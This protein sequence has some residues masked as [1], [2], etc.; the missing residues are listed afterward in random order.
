MKKTILFIV[1]IFFIGSAFAQLSMNSSGVVTFSKGF[2][3]GNT[4]NYFAADMKIKSTSMGYPSIT[5]IKASGYVGINVGPNTVSYPLDCRGTV[6]GYSFHTYSDARVKKNILDIENEQIWNILKLIP[7]E[8]ELDSTGSYIHPL[9]N[10]LTHKHFGLLAQDVKKIY[11]EIVSENND[12]L[13]SINYIELIP[14]LI[15]AIKEQQK[16]IESIQA[17]LNEGN[18]KSSESLPEVTE[19]SLSSSLM[20]NRPNPFSENTVIE[21]YL[22][23]EVSDAKIYIYNMN[24]TQLKNYDL[25]LIGNGSITINGGELNPGM[26]MYSLITDGQVIDTKRMILTD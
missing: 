17:Q 21:V 6:A 11:P 16:T 24:G 2:Y 12:G 22:A 1:S 20:Q 8:Y 7:K 4:I 13:M 14:L 9:D 18:I 15:G 26:Y 19:N 25:H 3:F 5:L 10:A 23:D